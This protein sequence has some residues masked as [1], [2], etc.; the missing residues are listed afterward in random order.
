M[1]AYAAGFREPTK[2][3]GPVSLLGEVLND[4]ATG[5]LHSSHIYA[6]DLKPSLHDPKIPAGA[7]PSRQILT[8][9][10]LVFMV[11]L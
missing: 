7:D 3:L 1:Q 10:I 6:L 5:Y 8:G 4:V 9:R 11:I 2:R